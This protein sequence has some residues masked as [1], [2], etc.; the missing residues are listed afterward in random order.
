MK[1]SKSI[2]LAAAFFT[3]I[4]TTAVAGDG[5]I[6]P[7]KIDDTWARPSIGKAGNSAAYM[8]ITNS[9]GAADTLVAV[10]TPYAGKAELHTHIRDKDIMRMRQVKGGIPVPANG[11]VELKPGGYHVMLMKLKEPIKKDTMIPLTLTFK[12]A[13]NVTV[14]ANIQ[15]SPGMKGKMDHGKSHMEMKKE[16]IHKHN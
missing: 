2:A 4:S 7:L 11:K 1:I 9:S 14:H 5:K 8:T 13:G 10:T 15:M 3:A 12:N 16:K 6:G